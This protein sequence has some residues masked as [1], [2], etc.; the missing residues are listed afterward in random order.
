MVGKENKDKP[1]P[2]YSVEY[3]RPWYINVRWWLRIRSAR[4]KRF[5]I[6]PL[7]P[8]FKLILIVLVISL[9]G[10]TIYHWSEGAT[11]G[12][13]AKLTT[14]DF[15]F[16]TKCYDAPRT[17]PKFIARNNFRGDSPSGALLVSGES[18][19]SYLTKSCVEL[20]TTA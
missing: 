12:D 11:L 19:D 16:V 13:A 17:I 1:R 14:W 3:S 7:V 10:L 6:R 15:R 18:V 2:D 5:A 20:K 8:L 9:L 4:A